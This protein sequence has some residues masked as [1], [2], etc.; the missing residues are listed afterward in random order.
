MVLKRICVSTIIG[1]L[2][3]LLTTVLGCST[4]DTGPRYADNP[5]ASRETLS[6][7]STI[8]ALMEGQYE[9]IITYEELGRYGDFGIGTFDDLDGEMVGFDGDFYQVKAD[10]TAYEVSGGMTAPFA[11]VTFFDV[12]IERELPGRLDYEQFREYVDGLLPEA[13]IFHAIVVEGEFSYMK[14]RSVPAQEE[15]FLPLDDVLQ[16]QAIFELN[17]VIGTMV[18]FRCPEFVADVNVPGYHLHFLSGDRT[19]GGHVLEFEIEDAVVSVD[20]TSDLYLILPD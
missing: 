7:V 4:R 20:Y 19:T 16:H 13:D 3:L 18:G 10:G 14:T 15:P 5:I 8:E 12:D 11:E 6:Q 1:T 2:C 17:D 9:G